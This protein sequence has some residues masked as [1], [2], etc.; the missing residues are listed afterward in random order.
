[1]WRGRTA[2][3]SVLRQDRPPPGQRGTL[4]RRHVLL[5]EHGKPHG[6]SVQPTQPAARQAN[7]QGVEDVGGSEGPPVIRGIGPPYAGGETQP[8]RV[9]TSH[10]SSRKRR[11]KGDGKHGPNGRAT[12]GTER[13]WLSAH[14]LAPDRLETGRADSPTPA[15]SDLPSGLRYGRSIG[16]SGMRGNSHVPFLGEG[17]MVTPPP[18]PT[19]VSL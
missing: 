4:R 1:M 19:L 15:P 12:S 13:P 16:L 7:T 6:W 2:L 3:E 8:E 5:A 11:K 9:L 14:C 17:A 18:Y 10:W